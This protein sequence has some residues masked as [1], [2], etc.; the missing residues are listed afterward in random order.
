MDPLRFA[1]RNSTLLSFRLESANF[2]ELIQRLIDLLLKNSMRILTVI[3][4]VVI[5]EGIAS[6]RSALHR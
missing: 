2:C 3:E 4:I 1:A 6:K 5:A